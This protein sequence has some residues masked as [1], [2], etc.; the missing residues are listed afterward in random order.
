MIK[1]LLTYVKFHKEIN[2]YYSFAARNNIVQDEHYNWRQ[3]TKY[4][5]NGILKEENN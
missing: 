2:K 5:L 1:L 4:W 3:R